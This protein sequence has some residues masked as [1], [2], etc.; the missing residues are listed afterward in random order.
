VLNGLII[1]STS[2]GVVFIHIMLPIFE[3]RTYPFLAKERMKRLS[4]M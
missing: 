3:S 4:F 2:F 1:K